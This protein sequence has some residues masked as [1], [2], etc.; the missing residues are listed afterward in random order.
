MHRVHYA[1]HSILTGTAIARALLDYAQALAG[2]VAAATV[3]IPTMRI[4][5]STGSSE[6]LIGP[7]S[8]LLADSEESERHEVIDD[9]LVASMRSEAHRIRRYGMSAPTAAITEILS[10]NDWADSDY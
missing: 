2:A 5:G 4:D 7:T 6:L 9:E 8:Q 10:P 1:G 3:Q